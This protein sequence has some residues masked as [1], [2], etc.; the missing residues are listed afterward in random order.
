MDENGKVLKDG[1]AVKERW[2]EYFK[3]LMN[4]KIGGPAK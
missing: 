2:R 3:N 4:A 1:A